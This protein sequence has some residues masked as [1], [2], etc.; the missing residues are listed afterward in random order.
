MSR[1]EIAVTFLK[2][3]G[4]GEVQA[5]YDKFI[6]PDFVH[7]N[8]YFKGD[9]QS[10]LTAMDEASRTN[11]NSS[12]EVEHVW[13]DG[14]TVVTHS[15]VVKAAPNRM[16]IAVVHIFR[17]EGGRVVELWDIGQQIP[18]NCPNENGAF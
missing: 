18:E 14:D 13:E 1:K 11:P 12:I 16:T 17:F 4:S 2:M 15:K 10:L 8:V 5:A 7:H 9:R 3:A 6:A